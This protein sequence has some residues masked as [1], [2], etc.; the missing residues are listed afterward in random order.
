MKIVHVEDVFHP[1]TGY[2]LNLLSKYMVAAGHDVVI[3]T[4]ETEKLPKGF[5]NFFGSE[6]IRRR[7]EIFTHNY[8][9]RIIRIPTKGYY[10]GRVFLSSRFFEIIKSEN[11]DVVYVHGNDTLTGM[12]YLLN[13]KKMKYPIVMDSHMLDMAAKNK[14]KSVFRFFYKTMFAPIIIKNLIPVIRT[15]DS[16]YVEKALGIPLSLAPWISTGSDTMVFKKDQI[17][18]AKMRQKNNIKENE[19]VVT[20]AGKLDEAKGG[21]LLARALREKINL[22]S[23]KICFIIIGNAVGEYGQQVEDIFSTSENRILRFGT[24]KY[25]ELAPFFQMSDLVIFP[26]QCSLSF[27]DAQACGIPV[28]FEDNEINSKRAVNGNAVTFKSNDIYDC[29]KKIIQIANMNASDYLSMSRASEELIK[30]SYDYK[31]ICD[32]YL[33]VIT[34]EIDKYNKNHICT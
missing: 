7:D 17:I 15:Q 21:M 8:G 30:E 12:R 3:I 5:M 19:F 13:L 6:N 34:K 20:Y 11:P 14:F 32:T 29:R 22:V 10:S 1:D 24:Q 23:K 2:Q 28:L 16:D 31:K 26:K 9:V 4:A 27:Y 18:R 25:M 33:D